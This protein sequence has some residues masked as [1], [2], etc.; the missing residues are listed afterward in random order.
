MCYTYRAVCE[1]NAIV[2]AILRRSERDFQRALIR[3]NPDNKSPRN[4]L[5]AVHFAVVWP[6]ALRQL[7]SAG[8]DID[9]QDN[10]ERRP[11][12]LAV[13][14]GSVESV[15]L[16]IEADCSLYTPSSHLGILQECL[17]LKKENKREQISALIVQGVINRHERLLSFASATLP[18]S[19]KV[20]KLR[21]PGKLQESLVPM[22]MEEMLCL[23][24]EIPIALKLGNKGHYEA[25]EPYKIFR[26]PISTAEQL[27]NGGFQELETPNYAVS[28]KVPLVLQAWSN[29][30]FDILRWVISK[31]ASPFAKHPSTGG[32]GLHWFASWLGSVGPYFSLNISRVC[33]DAGLV[34][35]LRWDDSAWRDSCSCCC[36]IV[37]CRPITIF[38]KERHAR[39]RGFSPHGFSEFL[40]LL[41]EFW[42]KVPPPPQQVLAQA[43]AVL[44]F[45][46]FDQTNAQHVASCCSVY[47]NVK[48]L[49][50]RTRP[51]PRWR[52]ASVSDKETTVLHN[53]EMIERK[54]QCYG[55]K[56]RH[57]GCVHLEMLLCVA[58]RD[59]CPNA[60]RRQARNRRRR[61]RSTRIRFPWH[62]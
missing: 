39:A 41:Q 15:N 54:M 18:Q 50:R 43:E 6:T 19:S 27:W 28:P 11:I 58:F 24:H 61:C 16:L 51:H 23:G 30:D 29:A 32:S 36:S 3:C 31:G 46:A 9:V 44:R 62:R 5:C 25:W 48:D 49:E 38:L 56:L 55:R 12:Q 60:R 13:A 7:I 22:I 40:H 17:M 4:G 59:I 2:S 47:C 33:S 20:F 42:A 45:F 26:L 8:A 10:F 57:C 1:H 37:G 14:L 35:Q 21:V 52:D 34:S 53:Y